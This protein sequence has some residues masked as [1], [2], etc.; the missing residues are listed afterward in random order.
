[1]TTQDLKAAI[2]NKGFQEEYDKARANPVF[3][4]IH[5]ADQHEVGCPH[6]EWSADEL[7]EALLT[8]KASHQAFIRTK[9]DLSYCR[10]HNTFPDD[11]EP[12]WQ[13]ANPYIDKAVKG[14]TITTRPRPDAGEAAMYEAKV[15]DGFL[16]ASVQGIC[17]AYNVPTE[18]FIPKGD[19]SADDW[20]GI[21][22]SLVAEVLTL[23]SKQEERP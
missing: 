22:Q 15:W 9:T 12:C 6:R 10:V 17:H 8:A 11:S 19:R 4:C 13:C 18:G 5:R 21:V 3:S 2:A 20:A 16:T 1:M 7:R 14:A 23:R